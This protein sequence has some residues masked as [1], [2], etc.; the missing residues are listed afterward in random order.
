VK[1]V[2]HALAAARISVERDGI[3]D[4]STGAAIARFQKQQSI[5]ISV[6]SVVDA[7]TRQ[8]LGLPA[9]VPQQDGRN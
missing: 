7:T 9:E 1:S 2:Q 3:Y 4:S 6:I 5:N 8:R